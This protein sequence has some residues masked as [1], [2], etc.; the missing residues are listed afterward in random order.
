MSR[1]PAFAFGGLGLAALCAAAPLAAQAPTADSLWAAGNFAA[2]KVEYERA[3]HDNPGWVRALYRLG[4]L[5]SWD[6]R[7][8]SALALFRDARELEPADADVRAAEARVL[9]WDGRYA[10]ALL[11]YDS[12]LAENPENRDA[13]FGRAQA[14]AW[15]G[16][17][18]EAEREY[19]ALIERNPEDAEALV[20]LA[21]LRQ[22][23]GRPDEAS[24]YATMALRVAPEDRA[25]R[26]V[27]QQARALSR[28]RLELT[29][30]LSHDSDDNNVWWQSLATSMV[31]ADGLRGFASVGA[32]EASDPVEDG[33]TRLH[34]EV[35]ASLSR[36]NLGLT[37]A[38]G[39]R[40]LSSDFGIDHSL[41]TWR[42][43]ASLRFGPGSG[44]GIG[45]AHYS[46]DETAGLISR[47]L[48]VD[49]LSLEGDVE[50]TRRLSLGLGASRG[51]LSDD[52][53]RQSF[54]VA[55]T[56]RVAPR[57]TVGLYGRALSYDFKGVG[58]FSPDPFLL[59]EARSA[60]TR[61]GGRWETRLSGGLGVQQIGSGARAQS[62]WHV[63]GRVA[64]RW[65]TINEV[66]LSAGFSTSAV[67]STTGAFDFYTMALSLRLGL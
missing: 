63:E 11:R 2:A 59:G 46:F 7:L 18:P 48:N 54:V 20:G 56:Q 4:I 49:E 17:H 61:V 21:Q 66:A 28:P 43:G 5:A 19:L 47:E 31:L 25:A 37:G 29:L 39:G 23:Q 55:L 12:L 16:R 41:A 62:E 34:G 45:Y 51:W 32:L 22:W 15:W 35:G 13:R 10:A 33:A 30:G 38:V 57:V 6:G 24:R 50:L 58:Y 14:N 3:L 53:S 65:A 9:A 8:D 52:N 64:R 60:W 36:G 26:E 27:A 1:I 42:A 44:A 67:S 40:K